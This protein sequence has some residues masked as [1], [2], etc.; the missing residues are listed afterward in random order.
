MCDR[1]NEYR[2]STVQEVLSIMSEAKKE[3]MVLTCHNAQHI[4]V[5]SMDVNKYIKQQAKN[6]IENEDILQ[7]YKTENYELKMTLMKMR[8]MYTLKETALRTS[9]DKKVCNDF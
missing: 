6:A 4:V 1:F 3:E 5:N 9:F 2:V 7:K 8:S